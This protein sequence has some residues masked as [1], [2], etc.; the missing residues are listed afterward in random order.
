M[1]PINFNINVRAQ[2]CYLYGGYIFIINTEGDLIYCSL[3]QFVGKLFESNKQYEDFLRLIF[4]RNDYLKN[5]QSEYFFNIPNLKGAFDTAWKRFCEKD[6]ET[7]DIEGNNFHFIC[8]IPEL[9]VYEFK[10]YAMRLYISTKS[11]MYEVV[12]K[13]VD[14]KR[15]QIEPSK[16]VKIFDQKVIGINAKSGVIFAS[17]GNEGLF[18]GSFLNEKNKFKMNERRIQEKSL[19]TGWS[20]YD[21]INYFDSNSFD[22]IINQTTKDA[23]RKEQYNHSKFDDK[24]EHIFINRICSEQ[25]SMDTLLKNVKFSKDNLMY[26]FNSNEYGF[27]YLD[28]GNFYLSSIIKDKNNIHFSSRQQ[29]IPLNYKQS[30]RPLSSQIIPGGCAIEFF[31]AI[32]LVHN[33]EVYDLEDDS[34]ISFRSYINSIRYHNLITVVKDDLITLHSIYPFKKKGGYLEHEEET[35]VAYR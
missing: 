9:P 31:D 2:D 27:F 3:T 26:C 25:I 8:K 17:A 6:S 28:D 10:A 12:L 19:K 15:Y 4:L 35:E 23:T 29:T 13:T 16:L 30:K 14:D 20:S 11:A 33:N 32:K 7:F 34:A 22:Y 21:I 5:K 18:H 1:K 24:K